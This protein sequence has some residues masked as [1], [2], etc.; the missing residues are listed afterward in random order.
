MNN[1]G[2]QEMMDQTEGTSPSGKDADLPTYAKSTLGN[3][4]RPLPG[5]QK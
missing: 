2:L 3:T 1:E 5:E 4:Q